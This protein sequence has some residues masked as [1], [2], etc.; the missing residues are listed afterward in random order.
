MLSSTPKKPV[1]PSAKKPDISNT[2]RLCKVTLILSRLADTVFPWR[3]C[4]KYRRNRELAA[5]P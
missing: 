2:C 5:L 4:L 3:I 1:K